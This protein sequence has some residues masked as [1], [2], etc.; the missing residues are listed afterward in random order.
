MPAQPESYAIASGE[1]LSGGRFYANQYAA[2]MGDSLT[3]DSYG[4][5]NFYALNGYCG[6]K[7]V[8]AANCGVSG[9]TVENM[10][11]RVNSL[12]TDALPGMAG[13]AASV[14]AEK[15][16]RI[17][18]RAGTNNI[19]SGGVFPTASATSLLNA[20]ATYA[21]RV[22]ILAVPPVA[23]TAGN[24]NSITANAWLAAFAA[25]NPS[26]FKFIDDSIHLRNQDGSQI[27]AYFADDVH[28]NHAGVGLCGDVA[29][30]AMASELSNYQSPLT[31][32]PADVY[33]AQPQWMPNPTNIGVGGTSGGGF[34]GV[35][36]NSITVGSYGTGMA[37]ICSIVAADAGDSNQMPWQRVE[38]TAGAIGSALQLSGT[39]VGRTITAI[40]PERLDMIMEIR[41]NGIDLTKLASFSGFAQ[42]STS[43]YL[44]PPTPLD[45]PNSGTSNRRYV[46]RTRRKRSAATTPAACHWYLRATVRSTFSASI[47]SIDFRCISIRG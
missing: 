5:S 20:L 15:L 33:P 47:G 36:A 34:T 46:L 32:D 16:G 44:V 21:T 22:I 35:V 40:D 39:M 1:V 12:Y 2:L 24:S 13:I 42:A 8:L 43:E 14:G 10:L 17:F 23:S 41:L 38:L 30:D 18:V 25:S 31:T 28:L 29:G 19:R 45:L 9:H 27:A 26:K 7:M 11:A 4:L 6:G 37:G 3:A